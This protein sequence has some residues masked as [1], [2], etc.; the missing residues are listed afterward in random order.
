MELL[1]NGLQL[2]S[3]VTPSFSMRTVLMTLVLGVSGPLVRIGKSLNKIKALLCVVLRTTLV[4]THQ[5]VLLSLRQNL[6]CLLEL[7]Y[8]AVNCWPNETSSGCDVNIEYDLEKEDMELN[9]VVISI[10]VP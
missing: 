7:L 3:G 2:H 8:F 4:F 6:E 10:P 5:R 1:E 9:D